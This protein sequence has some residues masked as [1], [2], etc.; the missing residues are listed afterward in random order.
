M[1]RISVL[2][3]HQDKEVATRES[4][5]PTLL[6]SGIPEAENS[7]VKDNSDWK[8]KTEILFHSFV[9][10]GVYVSLAE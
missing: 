9:V 5:Q 8:Q 10:S 7:G 6:S 1:C 4:P 2:H 3:G